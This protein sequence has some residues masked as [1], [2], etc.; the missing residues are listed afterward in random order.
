M[1]QTEKIG[2]KKNEKKLNEYENELEWGK[3]KETGNSFER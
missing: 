1:D 3:N 2:N